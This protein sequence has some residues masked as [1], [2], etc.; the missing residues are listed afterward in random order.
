MGVRFTVDR[1]H[2]RARPGGHALSGLLVMKVVDTE[3]LKV[4]GDERLNKPGLG[5]VR[6]FSGLFYQ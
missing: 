6:Q 3:V 5:L 1:E 2:E 4:H